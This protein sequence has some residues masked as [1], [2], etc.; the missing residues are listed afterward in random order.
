[1]ILL[2]YTIVHGQ[3][4][5]TQCLQEA[6]SDRQLRA[7]FTIRLGIDHISELIKLYGEEFKVGLA[8][9]VVNLMAILIEAG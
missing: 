5:I 3:M 9:H 1:M 7:I 4:W 8:H 2:Y 6:C